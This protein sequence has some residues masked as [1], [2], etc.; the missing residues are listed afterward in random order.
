MTKI[1]ILL[2]FLVSC[3]GGGGGGDTSHKPSPNNTNNETNE[4]FTGIVVD[5]LIHGATVCIDINADGICNVTEEKTTSNSNGSFSFPK[6]LIPKS[7]LVP[8]IANGGI[9]T[10]TGTNFEGELKAVIDVESEQSV[11]I[12]PL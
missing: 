3:T 11:V 4:L 12:N 6:D 7:G 1:L 5:G 8:I 9:D 10:A 2:T